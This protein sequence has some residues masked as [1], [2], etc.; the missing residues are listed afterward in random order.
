[1]IFASSYPTLDITLRAA[2]SL[3]IADRGHRDL[4]GRPFYVYKKY[5]L[6]K[7]LY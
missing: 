5:L 1:M 4:T 7:I 6:Y 3:L 2:L